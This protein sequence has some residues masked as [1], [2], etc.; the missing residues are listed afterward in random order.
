MKN[1]IVVLAGPV[2]L[3]MILSGCNE[4]SGIYKAGTYTASMNGYGG[5]IAV[6]VEFDANAILEVRVIEENETKEYRDLA[7]DAL[8]KK[9]ADE[10]TYDVAAITSATITSEAIKAAVKDCMEQAVVQQPEKNNR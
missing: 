10:Q 2:F 4:P 3:L 6:A 7:V 9:I 8:L 1:K 5:S